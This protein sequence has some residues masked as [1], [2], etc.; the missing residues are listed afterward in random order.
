MIAF[1]SSLSE[2]GSEKAFEK[3]NNANRFIKVK[4]LRD[5]K[6][7]T[8]YIDDVVVHDIVFLNSGDKVPCDGEIIDGKIDVDESVLTGETKEK[9]K[10]I[11][12]RIGDFIF[13]GLGT[14]GAKVN[15]NPILRTL[16]KFG[17]IAIPAVLGVSVL[18]MV[19]PGT[20]DKIGA[21]LDEFNKIY[22]EN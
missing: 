19:R 15:S 13:G 16:V 3:L 7:Q 8:I 9:K 4:V 18:D 12:S 11:F 1:I 21:S 10:S 6:K 22:G 2:Y 5:G 14:I 20:V 17:K